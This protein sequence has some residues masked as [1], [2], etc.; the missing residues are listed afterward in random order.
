MQAVIVQLF[1][2]FLPIFNQIR[3]DHA[4]AGNNSPTDDEM[5]AMLTA[6]ADKYL[7]EWA[8]WGAAHP[9]QPKP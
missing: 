4:A 3:A 9:K 2:I 7:N 8:L 6:N 1:A 5:K